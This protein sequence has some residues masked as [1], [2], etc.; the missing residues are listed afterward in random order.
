M[1]RPPFDPAAREAKLEAL[2]DKLTAA[3]E[4]LVTGDDWRRA[5]QFAAQLRSRSFSNTLLIQIQHYEA[6]TQGRV[7]NPLPTYVAGFKQWHGLERHVIKGQAGYAI[8]AP[9]TGRFASST[10]QDPM[11]WRR[12]KRGEKPQPGEMARS[13]MIGVRPTHVWDVSQTDGRP[14]PEP[15]RPA[16]LKGQAPVGLWD[17]L[18]AAI[19]ARGFTVH[20]VPH[21]TDIGGANGITDFVTREVSVRTDMD[22]AAQVKTLAHEL[23]HVMLHAPDADSAVN[24][25]GVAEVEAESVALMIGA[26]HGMA[27]DEYTIPYVASW[28]NSVPGKAPV[29]VVQATAARVRGAAVTILEALETQQIGAG[30][31]PGRTRETTERAA[32]TAGLEAPQPSVT[33]NSAPRALPAEVREALAGEVYVPAQVRRPLDGGSV[34]VEPPSHSA[35]R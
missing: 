21:S 11:S 9:V 29:E 10:P 22:E 12:L 5:L 23:G 4:A 17:G 24:H 16:L 15:K 3:V 7:P 25:R 14:I 35:G 20:R 31:P 1:G 34:G 13:R 33:G 2:Q 27:T 19:E 26:A 18:T 32:P 28:A 6:Y 8:L 30:D